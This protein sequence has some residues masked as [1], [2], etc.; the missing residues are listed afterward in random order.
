MGSSLKVRGGN[1]YR[2]SPHHCSLFFV[3]SSKRW[4]VPT[5]GGVLTGRSWDCYLVRCIH[6]RGGHRDDR[7]LH[8]HSSALVHWTVVVLT[9]YRV[10][11]FRA[12]AGRS[13]DNAE[14]SILV[15]NIAS[16]MQRPVPA[17][18]ALAELF[19]WQWPT[20]VQARARKLFLRSKLSQKSCALHVFLD[21]HLSEKCSA[22]FR[23]PGCFVPDDSFV[24][25]RFLET[26]S[27]VLRSS[28]RYLH[29]STLWERQLQRKVLS[30]RRNRSTACTFK[31]QMIVSSGCAQ[32]EN[33][34]H[35]W[36]TWQKCGQLT[37][38]FASGATVRRRSEHLSQSCAQ[39]SSVGWSP[40]LV[41]GTL[42]YTPSYFFLNHM[43]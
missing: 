4:I 27:S 36:C 34:L 42:C 21:Y 25:F 43:V 9:L 6:S 11:G 16:S 14:G 38:C 33:M 26:C 40:K 29:F 23:L 22:A 30:W 8:C 10:I 39:H 17:S 5:L 7:V 41:S 12:I 2:S 31:L 15:H 13:L 18:P 19:T 20:H 32:S 3:E 37:R 28:I 1:V 35:G 24:Q